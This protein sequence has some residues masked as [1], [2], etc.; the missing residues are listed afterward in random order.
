MK[1]DRT[2]YLKRLQSTFKP[3]SVS[4]HCHPVL[5]LSFRLTKS[6]G[7]TEGAILSTLNRAVFLALVSISSH[8]PA[9]EY[10]ISL[11]FVCL[12]HQT[13]SA[14][15]QAKCSIMVYTQLKNIWLS[16][17]GIQRKKNICVFCFHGS[18]V[19]NTYLNVQMHTHALV[20]VYDAFS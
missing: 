14:T 3:Y 17:I 9:E 8:T 2:R 6:F 10:S 16:G 15:S 12:S 13:R 7:E 18:F 11:L 5:F 20:I 19:T 4:L 1:K